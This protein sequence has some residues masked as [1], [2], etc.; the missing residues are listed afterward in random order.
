MFTNMDQDSVG[1]APASVGVAPASVGVASDEVAWQ[2][3]WKEDTDDKIHGPF[4]SQQMADWQ[5]QG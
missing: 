4:T 5:E 2:Y 3:K 1:V